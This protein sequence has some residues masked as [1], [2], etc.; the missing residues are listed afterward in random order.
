MET[1]VR[2]ITIGKTVATVISITEMTT[3][4]LPAGRRVLR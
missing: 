3:T 1:F 4:T 2:T